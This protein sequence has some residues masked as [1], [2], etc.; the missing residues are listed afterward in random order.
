MVEDPYPPCP[1]GN[2]C[3]A[4]HECLQYTVDGELAFSICV[5]TG[6]AG[7]GECPEPTS[8]NASPVCVGGAPMFCTLDCAG[9]TEG[10]PDGMDCRYVVDFGVWR[11]LWPV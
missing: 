6:C 1:M 8:G 4:T 11:C 5:P 9:D 2:E 10:C 3:P 7:S